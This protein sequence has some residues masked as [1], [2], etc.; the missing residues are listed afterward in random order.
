MIYIK[1]NNI[2]KYIGQ[3]SV[4]YILLRYLPNVN[5]KPID[6]LLVSLIIVVLYT[7]F[8]KLCN[9]SNIITDESCNYCSYDSQSCNNSE[10][11]EHFLNNQADNLTNDL[12]NDDSDNNS[13]L[14]EK[15]NQADDK[16]NQSDDKNN[17]DLQT[18]NV[19][20]QKC[21]R[22]VNDCADAN[23]VCALTRDCYQEIAKNT[24]ISSNNN[25]IHSDDDKINDK[26]HE[27]VPS[28]WHR[29]TGGIHSNNSTFKKSYDPYAN[30]NTGLSAEPDNIDGVPN[31]SKIIGKFPSK[32][33]RLDGSHGNVMDKSPYTDFNTVPMGSG[34]N[35]GNFESGYAFLPPSK[36]YP[37]P[38]IPPICVTNKRTSIFPVMDPGFVDLKEWN[39]SLK[40]TAD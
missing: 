9:N 37:E 30:V 23:G 32:S 22:Q 24:V 38:P 4:I 13:H 8:E 28:E 16:N 11:N 1:F 25:N 39:S 3:S 31:N 29:P 14:N 35:T 17:Q 7:L 10:I 20:S 34:L 21:V 5:L 12:I 19:I 26:E 18:T 33:Y 36:W 6:C 40:I 27:F 2:L 15:N